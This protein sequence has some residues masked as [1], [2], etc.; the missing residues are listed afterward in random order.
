MDGLRESYRITAIVLGI[1]LL[2]SPAFSQTEKIEDDVCLTCHENYDTGLSFTT[3]RLSSEIAKPNIE[4]GC[5]SC[6]SGGSVHVDDPSV[7]NIGNP[8]NALSHL[9]E[10]TCTNC[11]QPH[12]GIRATGFDP[13]FGQDF[14]CTS[15]HKIHAQETSLL[16]DE[17]GSFCSGCHV[18]VVNDFR[19]RSNHP[20]TDQAMTCM[21]CHDFTGKTNM[22]FGHGSNANCY[23]CHPE[24]GGPFLHEHEAASSFAIEGEGCISCH[25]PHGS[26]NDRLL[27]QPGNRLCFQCHS[28]P[29][30]HRTQHDGIATRFDCV[31][32]HTDMHGSYTSRMFLDPQLSMNIGG[33]AIACFCHE[34]GN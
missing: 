17:E 6:H 29:P 4:I 8:A 32:C 11:H 9:T 10:S 18:S 28:T 33:T 23:Q 22:N 30:L 21:S 7:E 13:H 15:C 14:S 34:S 2:S 12:K 25:T 27:V 20:L 16:I 5:I 19:K 26:A 3:H 31:E 24:Q 1:I